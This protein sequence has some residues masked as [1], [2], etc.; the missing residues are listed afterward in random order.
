MNLPQTIE[1]RFVRRDNR[2]RVA[3][4]IDGEEVAAHLPNSG[5]LG[6]LLT[7]GRA[8]YL[9]PKPGAHRRTHFDLLLVA[10]AGVL[11]SV[12][13]RLPNTL[14]AEAVATGRLPAFAGTT[15]IEPEV[16]YGHSRLDFRLGGEDGRCWVEAKSVTLVEEG[17]ALFPDAPTRRGQRHLEELASL[18]RR[19]ERAAV[20]F[21]VQ[22]PDPEAFRAHAEADPDFARGLAEA[23]AA[24]VEAYAFRC[25]VTQEE[26]RII[27]GI[28]VQV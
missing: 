24:G 19:G 28:P 20:V 21:V 22:R 25:A 3:V 17:M 1:G 7:P 15:T 18:A 23:V 11:V 16:T 12:D 4:E 14:F 6:E 13:A 26:M 8:C 5:R 2:F 10:Y 9:V 27:A